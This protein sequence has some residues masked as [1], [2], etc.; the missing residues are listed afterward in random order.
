MNLALSA[1]PVFYSH[2]QDR[3]MGAVGESIRKSIVVAL[4]PT[5]DRGDQVYNRVADALRKAE[6]AEGML[7]SPK[8]F[9]RTLELL[10]ALPAEIPLP[11]VVIESETEIGLDWDEGS[12]RVLSLTVRDT[13]MVGFA[14]LYEGEPLHG[15]VRFVE[16]IPETLRF[17]LARLFPKRRAVNGPN[18]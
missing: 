18:F 10:T 7:T 13:P 11:D 9:G 17:L 6:Q 14:A 15:R 3:S 4:E 5:I 16:E 12:Q 2:D 8:A 1:S